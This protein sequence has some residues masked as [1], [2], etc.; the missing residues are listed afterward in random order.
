MKG[1]RRDLLVIVLALAVITAGHIVHGFYRAEYQAFYRLLYFIP[2]LM[3]AFRFGLKGGIAA[4]LVAS[5]LYLPDTALFVGRIPADQLPEVL[6]ILL[7]NV[8]GWIVGVMVQ[9]QER[10][11]RRYQALV[12]ELAV[13]ASEKRQLEEQ[14]HRAEHLAGLGRLVAGIAHEIRNPLGIANATVQ[15]MKKEYR[16]DPN[17]GEYASVILEELERLNTA[18]E[19]F[20]NFAR[21]ASDERRPLKAAE[22]IED[23]RSLMSRYLKEHAVTM[24][25]DAPDDLPPIV[26][27]GGAIRGALVNLIFNSVDAM[28]SGGRLMLSAGL[29]QNHLKITVS[30]TGAG[31]RP[32][33]RPKIFDPF[34]TTKETGFGL[35]L[36]VVHR[37]IDAHGGYIEVDSQPG[38][39][40]S[41]SLNLPLDTGAE[42]GN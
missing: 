32:E 15:V 34:F 9:S 6:D 19:R 42:A 12:R 35:G 2:V 11:N 30:D 28:P 24:F 14:I 3:A 7:F 37:I 22:L 16:D 39:G 27:D 40:T 36:S 21:P 18:I 4:P 5:V 29:G 13:R 20:L 31:I 8:V 33:D 25:V 26:A 38:K 17:L 41:V 23:V 1:R 10:K